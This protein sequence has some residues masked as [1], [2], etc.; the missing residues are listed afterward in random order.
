[1]R[2]INL[3]IIQAPNLELLREFQSE[4]L[5]D[6]ARTGYSNL[7]SAS[8]NFTQ[9]TSTSLRINAQGGDDTIQLFGTGNDRIFTGSGDDFVFAG[10]G[11]DTVTGGSGSDN[12][13]GFEG[14]D[15]LSGGSGNDTIEGGFGTD[16]ISG[17]SGNDDLF[18][19]A[20]LDII[21]GGIG[22]DKLFGDHDGSSTSQQGG[23]Y[24][25]GGSGNDEIHGGGRSDKMYGNSGADTFVFDHVNDF[26]FG[27]ADLIGD[28]SRTEGDLIV[29]TPVDAKA[30]QS[31][32][33]NFDFVDGPS[34]QAG[35]LWL[36]SVNNGLQRVFMNTDGGAADLDILVRFNDETMI[37]LQESDF[38]L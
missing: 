4:L 1:M 3:E 5:Q 28:F 6:V 33:Q 27:H 13:I 21:F 7:G 37:S 9:N 34:Q 29:L 24:L 12:L 25:Y 35:T 14:N 2:S 17:G 8:N 38:Q 10:R 31:G 20:G 22:N 23:D 11:D 15:K 26:V 19:G 18:G 36:G 30:T 16:E 32:N